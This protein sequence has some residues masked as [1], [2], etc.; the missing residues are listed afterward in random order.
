[1]GLTDLRRGLVLDLTPSL[2]AGQP[3]ARLRDGWDYEGGRPELGGTVRWG[4]T[5]NLTLNGT[6][7]PD[8]SQVESDA[9]QF[10]FDPRQ[11]LFFSE[12]RPFFLDGIEQ[13][14]TP[15][16][17]IY[18]RRV[19]QPTAAAKLNGKVFGTDL[20]FLSR[21]TIPPGRGAG[22]T[23]RCTTCFGCR[24]MSAAQSRLGFVYTDR[25][26]GGDY[27]RVAGID[28]RLSVQGDLQRAVPAGREPDRVE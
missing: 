14:N 27:N 21:S 2:T 8:F 10:S 22:E 9:A 3:A 6:A 23:T 4:I 17:L 5:N 20:A 15:N 11:E 24:R 16:Q 7:N 28:G 12:K 13:F 18:T 19:V 25:I 26:A 1:M